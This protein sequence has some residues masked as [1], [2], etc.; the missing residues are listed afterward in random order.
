MGFGVASDQ[1][2]TIA[3]AEANRKQLEKE[4]NF[5][6]GSV[7]NNLGVTIGIGEDVDSVDMQHPAFWGND[8]RSPWHTLDSTSV[9][10]TVSKDPSA[11]ETEAVRAFQKSSDH[12]TH[13]A[14]LIAA[15]S[16]SLGPGIAPSANL[17]LLNTS[18]P[19]ATAQS[20]RA[21]MNNQVY[22]F[23]LSF[24]VEQNNT[25]VPLKKL[26]IGN[27]KDRLFIVA[28]GDD[29]EDVDKLEIAPV[30]W[31]NS[32]PNI[33]GVAASDW[34]KQI[35]GEMINQDGVR[36][37]GSNYGR[38][39]VQLAA[40]GKDIFSTLRGGGYGEASGT[41]QAVP[42]VSATA[43]ILLA[44]GI[45]DPLV[46]KQRLLYTADWYSPNFDGKLWGGGLLV[47]CLAIK[48]W[49]PH[50]SSFENSPECS[51]SFPIQQ[52]Y[53]YVAAA[54]KSAN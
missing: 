24:A 42:L 54:P 51:G 12:G 26:L 40:P 3:D 22:I 50:N 41:S 5:V 48:N 23:S 25:A 21:A 2:P 20:I 7:P 46:I 31:A 15:R 47:N 49:N 16:G 36:T 4:I 30:G 39:F 14:G 53:D 19:A 6:A 29:G 38:N 1:P 13:V 28:A 27:A 45:T 11:S 9:V 44:E 52:F 43:A 10:Q 33:I 8:S 17:L 34:S 32:A 18:N 35:L 37:K